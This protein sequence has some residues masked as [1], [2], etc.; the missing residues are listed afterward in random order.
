MRVSDLLLV[1]WC[2]VEK[3]N[4]PWIFCTDFPKNQ[5]PCTNTNYVVTLS[6][7][8]DKIHKLAFNQMA[9]VREL[10]KRQ[11]VIKMNQTEYPVSEDPRHKKNVIF[12]LLK[13]LFLKPT[14]ILWIVY[15]VFSV[16]TQYLVVSDAI[17]HTTLLDSSRGTTPTAMVRSLHVVTECTFTCPESRRY[18]LKNH[19]RDS[20]QI[21]ITAPAEKSEVLPMT[22]LRSPEPITIWE[23]TIEQMRF[24]FPIRGLRA[25]G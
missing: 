4:Y 9:L 3:L 24:L 15:L 16:V 17:S 20:H 10:Q 14:K 23:P 1:G 13:H 7:R 19:L 22:P 2:L 12:I 25:V 18:M 11:Y 21:P 6:E 8:L 5:E